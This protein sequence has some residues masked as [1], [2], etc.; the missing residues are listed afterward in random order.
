[1]LKKKFRL[2]ASLSLRQAKTV[3]SALFKIRF[4][5]N[6]LSFNRFAF[7]VSKRVDKKAVVRNK[8][9]RILR[10]CVQKN[11]DDL[12]TGY[13]ILFLAKSGLK[14]KEPEI[15]SESIINTLRASNLL[16]Q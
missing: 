13:D 9:K 2:S 11:I 7:V 12:N 15:I 1:M 6:N 8:I 10:E 16:K 3:D 4:L 5:K 14:E